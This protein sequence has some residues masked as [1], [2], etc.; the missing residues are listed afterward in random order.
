M[1]VV[2]FLFVTTDRSTLDNFT[3]A[4]AS[5]SMGRIEQPHAQKAS[6]VIL[7]HIYNFAA[8]YQLI[9]GLGPKVYATQVIYA[10]L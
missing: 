9:Q 6:G 4:Q 8:R 1:P 10:N 2:P 5:G 7:V 3:A